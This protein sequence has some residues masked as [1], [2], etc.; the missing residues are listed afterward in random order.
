[1]MVVQNRKSTLDLNDPRYFTQPII[2][3]YRNKTRGWARRAAEGAAKILAERGM[4]PDFAEC[5][6]GMFAVR[7]DDGLW[8][9]LTG[10]DDPVFK[11]WC[12]RIFFEEAPPQEVKKNGR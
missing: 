3:P 5:G 11:R 1:M 4:P 7:D 12:A 8:K 10:P 9:I 6:H 2:L